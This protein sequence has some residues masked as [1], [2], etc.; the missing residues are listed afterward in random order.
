MQPANFNSLRLLGASPL[1][2]AFLSIFLR[3]G[4]DFEDPGWMEFFE[5]TDL[6][7]GVGHRGVLREF[8]RTRRPLGLASHLIPENC[9]EVA[10]RDRCI[11]YYIRRVDRTQQTLFLFS[12]LLGVYPPGFYVGREVELLDLF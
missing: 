7:R 8:V 2:T 1:N 9:G 10:L 6:H 11:A 5:S 3:E 4:W 12:E